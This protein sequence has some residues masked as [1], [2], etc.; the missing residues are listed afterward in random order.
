MEIDCSVAAVTVTEITFEVTPLCA[1]LIL[2]EPAA[3][4]VARPAP[5]I[6]AAAGFDEFH[7]A[8]FVRFCVVPSVN[9]PVALN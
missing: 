6:V 4:A 9:V 5:V 1:A 2:A 8:E 3:T 7:V